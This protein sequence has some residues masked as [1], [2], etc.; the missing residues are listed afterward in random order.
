[1]W[2]LNAQRSAH[3]EQ[4]ISE[5]LHVQWVHQLPRLDPA[6]K[7]ARLQFDAG[8]EP[9][10]KNGILFYGSS[11]TNSI[12]AIDVKTGKERWHFFTNGP[13]RLA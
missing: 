12:T 13:I 5:S 11:S 3:T 9:I 1:M 2:R 7:N 10:V 6:F 4:K 8:Y